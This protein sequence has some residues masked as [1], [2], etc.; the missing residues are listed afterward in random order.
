ME[1]PV[2][3]VQFS[4]VKDVYRPGDVLNVAIF[5]RKPWVG[6]VEVGLSSD[7]RP[8][9]TFHSSVFARSNSAL[10]EGQVHVR[11]EHI[12]TCR[13]L[14]RLSGVDGSTSTDPLVGEPFQ[15]RPISP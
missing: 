7:A 9:G 13:L 4:P 1:T 5:F 6:E 15:V 3:H 8:A 11:G 10:Y 12:G 2:D 14:A